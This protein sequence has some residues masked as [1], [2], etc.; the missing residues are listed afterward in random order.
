SPG[1]LR[2]PFVCLIF[3]SSVVTM[4]QEHSLIK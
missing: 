3:H 2:V 4:S 1:L